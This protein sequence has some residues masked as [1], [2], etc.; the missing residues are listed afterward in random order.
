M[1][2]SDTSFL[3]FGGGG[4]RCDLPRAR[5]RG[6]GGQ[7]V[8]LR[9]RSGSS[10]G[11]NGRSGLDLRVAAPGA[12]ESGVSRRPRPAVGTLGRNHDPGPSTRRAGPFSDPWFPRVRAGSLDAAPGRAKGR[13]R[14]GR[15]DRMITGP[16]A[17]VPSRSGGA[18][19]RATLS[20]GGSTAGAIRAYGRAAKAAPAA[21]TGTMGRA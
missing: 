21:G 10:V 5:I 7:L 4:G 18:G 11:V 13:R 16:G 2:A 17:P 1:V 9:A 3:R 6:A 12:V 8:P 20:P 15:P 19:P 14:T